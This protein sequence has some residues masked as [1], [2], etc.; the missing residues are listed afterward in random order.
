MFSAAECRLIALQKIAQAERDKR[1]RRTLTSAAEAWLFLA[2][3]RDEFEGVVAV[4]YELDD[5]MD[6]R[7]A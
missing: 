7:A 3:Q 6:Y 1:N 2:R 4:A 5:D